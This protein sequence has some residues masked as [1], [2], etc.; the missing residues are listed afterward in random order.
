MAAIIGRQVDLDVLRT[1]APDADLDALL[2]VCGNAAI[3][4][5]YGYQ[6]RFTHDKLREAL[7]AEMIPPR[8]A[9]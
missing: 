2:V 4:E 9:R 7:L 6:W 3:L 5:G 8:A 1:A